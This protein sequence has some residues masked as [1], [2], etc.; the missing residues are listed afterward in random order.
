MTS[1]LEPA[2]QAAKRERR[3]EEGRAVAAEQPRSSPRPAR[4]SPSRGLVRITPSGVLIGGRALGAEP[5]QSAYAETGRG[6]EAR[7]WGSGA[8][9]A[10]WW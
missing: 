1:Q 5:Q 3:E 6:E 2:Q 7:A 4:R 8:L 10:D 9:G